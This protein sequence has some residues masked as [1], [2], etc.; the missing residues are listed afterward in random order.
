MPVLRTVNQSAISFMG[1][2]GS[3]ASPMPE[4]PIEMSSNAVAASPAGS[5]RRPSVVVGAATFE[6][7]SDGAI[8]AVVFMSD[9]QPCAGGPLV[10]WLV[11]S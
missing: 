3:G 9:P 6:P 2:C 7:R 10:I 8:A 4:K 11:T 1:A 5:Q